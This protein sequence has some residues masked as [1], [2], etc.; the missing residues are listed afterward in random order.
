ML[1]LQRTVPGVPNRAIKRRGRS[2]LA[3]GESKHCQ[4]RSRDYSIQT[5]TKRC[6][7]TSQPN[8]S[9]RPGRHIISDPL[10]LH[11]CNQFPIRAAIPRY[12]RSPSRMSCTPF[13]CPSIKMLGTNYDE[14]RCTRGSIISSDVQRSTNHCPRPPLQLLPPP[15]KHGSEGS[16]DTVWGFYFGLLSVTVRSIS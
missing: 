2:V 8:S 16:G 1:G 9:S 4:Q 10:N 5:H 15:R 11:P 7:G 12:C 6:I 3:V 14:S 13:S